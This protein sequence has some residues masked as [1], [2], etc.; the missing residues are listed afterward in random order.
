MLSFPLS[1]VGINGTKISHKTRVVPLSLTCRE[2]RLKKNMVVRTLPDP[3][4]NLHMTDWNLFK[5]GWPHFK[6]FVLPY[7]GYWGH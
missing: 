3:A 7:L 2:S 4:G 5:E 1:V 6:V